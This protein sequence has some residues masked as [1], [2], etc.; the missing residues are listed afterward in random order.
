MPDIK[1]LANP[2]DKITLDC[3]DID[4][5]RIAVLLVGRGQYCIIGDEM[6]LFLFGGHEQ[7]FQKTYG[8]S[9]DDLS[10]SVDPMRVAAVLK[11]F[12]LVHG[13][14]SSVNDPVGYAHHMAAGIEKRQEENANMPPVQSAD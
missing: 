13:G 1:E 9:L 7:W 12:S 11:S 14:R 5:A 2:H 3:E 8:K 6:P 10:D 4:A